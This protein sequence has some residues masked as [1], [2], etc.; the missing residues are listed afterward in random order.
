[1]DLV[2]LQKLLDLLIYVYFIS[3]HS[4][5]LTLAPSKKFQDL[6]AL[7]ADISRKLSDQINASIENFAKSENISKNSPS[8]KR[9]REDEIVISDSEDNIGK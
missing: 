5:L 3:L 4:L 8:S 2:A 1:M 9:K 6:S 7:T